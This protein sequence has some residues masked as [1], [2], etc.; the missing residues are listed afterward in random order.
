LARV[1]VAVRQLRLPRDEVLHFANRFYLSQHS[2]LAATDAPEQALD[3]NDATTGGEN[4][5]T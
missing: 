2:P 3:Q 5:A 4:D 1:A